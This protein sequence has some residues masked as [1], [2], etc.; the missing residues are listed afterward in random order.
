MDKLKNSKALGS[1][2]KQKKYLETDLKHLFNTLTLKHEKKQESHKGLDEIV[3][4]III[5]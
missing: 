3:R 1:V 4:E 2:D 5:V